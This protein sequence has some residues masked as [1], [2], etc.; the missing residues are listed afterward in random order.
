MVPAAIPVSTPDA[1]IVATAVLLL[2]HVP[3]LTLDDSVD[4]SPV[5]RLVEP[6]MVPAEGAGLTVAGVI[7]RQPVESA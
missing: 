3:P 6:D 4:V 7:L 5:Q 2:L 1:S